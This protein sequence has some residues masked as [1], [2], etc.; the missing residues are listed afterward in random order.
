MLCAFSDYKRR[1]SEGGAKLGRILA[2]RKEK[3]QEQEERRQKEQEQQ[4]KEQEQQQKEQGESEGASILPDLDMDIDGQIAA[5]GGGGGGDAP[6]ILASTSLAKPV[7]IK[8]EK[9][10]GIPTIT[11]EPLAPDDNEEQQQ[12]QSEKQGEEEVRVS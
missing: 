1:V 3:A 12:E 5:N 10:A 11:F 7:S 8:Q 2:M 4:Q 9:H 6:R